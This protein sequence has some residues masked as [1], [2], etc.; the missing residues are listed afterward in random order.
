MLNL[1]YTGA[2]L[3][4]GSHRRHREDARLAGEPSPIFDIPFVLAVTTF[5]RLNTAASQGAFNHQTEIVR[6]EAVAG[7]L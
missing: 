6:M 2:K 4:N 7:L 1:D 5:T 3:S